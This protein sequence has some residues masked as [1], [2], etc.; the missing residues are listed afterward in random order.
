VLTWVYVPCSFFLNGY[1]TLRVPLQNFIVTGG[2]FVQERCYVKTDCMVWYLA[3]SLMMRVGEVDVRSQLSLSL[4]LSLFLS[5]SLSLSRS[6]SSNKNESTTSQM[7]I[8]ILE[9]R[10]SDTQLRYQ[11][12]LG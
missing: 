1:L 6:H 8:I 11:L 5:I 4:S 2:T 9:A 3:Q 12:Q 7:C 10:R